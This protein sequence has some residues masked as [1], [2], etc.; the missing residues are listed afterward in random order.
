MKATFAITVS[1]EISSVD[2]VEAECLSLELALVI[3]YVDDRTV[4]I[5]E[6]LSFN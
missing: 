4:D 1:K 2:V 6:R 5:L 3:V